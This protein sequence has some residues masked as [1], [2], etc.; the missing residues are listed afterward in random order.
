[1][2]I[3]TV[4]LVNAFHCYSSATETQIAQ[5]PAMND[6]VGLHLGLHSVGLYLFR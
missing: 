5:T 4:N 2:S 1:L 3:F 6:Y